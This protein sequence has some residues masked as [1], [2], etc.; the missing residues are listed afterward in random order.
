MRKTTLAL[1]CVALVAMS[2]GLVANT[3]ADGAA[4]ANLRGRILL[5]VEENGE[6]WYIN[7][8][9]GLRYYLGRPDD[10]FAIMKHLGLGA[11]HNDILRIPADIHPNGEESFARAYAGRILLDTQHHGEA[12]YI[13]PTDLRGYYM[14]RPMDAFNLMR[15]RGTGATNTTVMSLAPNV[16]ISGIFYK[17]FWNNEAD[18]FVD[19]K[20]HGSMKQNIYKWTIDDTIHTYNFPN[21]TLYP[22][23]SVR[24]Y[25]NTGKYYFGYNW[26]IWNNNGDTGYLRA[27]T[28]ALVDVF[29]Y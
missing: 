13:D 26:P 24:V 7:P 28:N 11:T 5:Q 18:E 4:S 6:A 20:N 12:W 21:I 9:D 1:L 8:V 23:Q 2:F 25:T 27:E 22:G 29:G 3:Y 10:A 17:G 16:Q 15:D 19:I 14:G